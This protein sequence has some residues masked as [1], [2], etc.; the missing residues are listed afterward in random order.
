MAELPSSVV[1]KLQRF[2][3]LE[4]SHASLIEALENLAREYCEQTYIGDPELEEVIIATRAV[5]LMAKE[6]SA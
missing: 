1:K 2:R 5:L 6:L 3:L 4:E